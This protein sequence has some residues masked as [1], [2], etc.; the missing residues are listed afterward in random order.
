MEKNIPSRG[1][2]KRPL[3][4]WQSGFTLIEL[5]I[6]LAI[7]GILLAIA[8]PNFISFVQNSRLT[9]QAN[10]F[11]TALNYARSEAIKRGV[12]TTV[13]SRATDDSCA[14]STTWD[15]GW[16][17]FVDCDFDG[18][19]DDGN[20]PDWDANGAADDEP[21]LLVRQPLESGNTLR[22]TQRQRVTYQN[23]GY[24]G[25][26]D[27]FNLCDSRGTASGRAITVNMQGRVSTTPVA[28]SCP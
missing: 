23:T 5:I 2:R 6:T 22:A 15:A 9:N 11:V 1:I 25:F 17:V 26:A 10:D 8:V 18:V 28:S 12:R 13:C 14:G 7:A 20:C 27:R 16:L 24:S 4:G 3:S 21:V 19:V